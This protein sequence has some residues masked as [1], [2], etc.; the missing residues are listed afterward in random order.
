MCI[1]F[2]CPIR[3]VL[4]LPGK[5]CLNRT[6]RSFD[7]R[8][9]TLPLLCVQQCTYSVPLS[10]EPERENLL[11]RFKNFKKFGDIK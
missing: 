6:M 7:R 1:D 3:G 5:T 10:S 2:S 11:L 9:V 8:K 4:S